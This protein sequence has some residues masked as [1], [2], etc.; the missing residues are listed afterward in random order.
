MKQSGNL[1]TI[2]GRAGVEIYAQNDRSQ[3]NYD[4]KEPGI[5]LQ[6]EIAPP[7]ASGN[8]AF[9]FRISAR[10]NSPSTGSAN[11]QNR[12]YEAA[13]RGVAPS[14]P[15]RW[16]VG[17]TTPGRVSGVG[18][19]DG[20]SGEYNLTNDLRLGLF[21]GA[22]PDW[23]GGATNWSRRKGGI[24]ASF[25]HGDWSKRRIA[26]SIAVV[27][28]YNKSVI[29]REF[30]YLDNDLVWNP[31]LSFYQSA[32][33]EINRGWRKQAEG[34]ALTL[35]S[36]MFSVHYAITNDLSINFGYDDR[37]PIH[38]FEDRATPDS[39]FDS[40]LRMGY[41]GGL[42]AKLPLGLRGS[43][44]AGYNTVSGAKVSKS[45][46][47]SLGHP[48]LFGTGISTNFRAA[49][50]SSEFS[51]GTQ[52]SLSLNRTVWRDLSLGLQLGQ[53][54]YNYSNA[55]VSSVTSRWVRLSADWW[56]ASRFYGSL[57]DE[58][59]RGGGY[60]ADRLYASLGMR[61]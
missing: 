32:E 15:F 7:M 60:D 34:S 25:E 46:S 22:D 51:S 5:S 40:A 61:F 58:I 37:T 52:P 31:K 50:F 3:Y 19:L 1:W 33:L 28:S 38:Y 8:V 2:K 17:R 20:I 12:Y 48:S 55:A 47:L 23:G 10:H 16:A 9:I 45:G 27:G 43:V 24:T 42:N 14:M 26:S 57:T 39:M 36:L 56:F 29:E 21:A 11:W 41:R 18:Y 54:H 59:Q 53:N 4:Y 6:G 44:D 13:F 30:V 49:W 35:S